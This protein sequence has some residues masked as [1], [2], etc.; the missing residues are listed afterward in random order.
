MTAALRA[1]L[2]LLVLAVSACKPQA[3]E[4]APT[5][6]FDAKASLVAYLTG[7][8]GVHAARGETWID[9]ADDARVQ[10]SVCAFGPMEGDPRRHFL[11]A[12]CGEWLARGHSSPGLVDFHLLEPTADGFH[13]TATARDH[14]F[15][16]D[17]HPGTVSLV[18]L[19]RE[20]GGFLV[21]EG[22]VGQGLVTGTRSIVEF[23]DG[24]LRTLAAVRSGIA[25]AGAADCLE[26]ADC[27]SSF[28]V[29]F[30]QS[31]DDSAPAADAYPLLV[32]ETG[33][34]CGAEVDRRHRFAFDAASG[35]YPV[36]ATL[37]RE[38]CLRP[39]NPDPE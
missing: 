35:R 15:G 23:R 14:G 27:A 25:N 5:P 18:R 6:A 2:A 20:R 1:V 38:D 9:G 21:E 19:G 8:Y 31:L 34:E 32:H 26:A 3:P 13:P 36:P 10:R 29:D 7:V 30:A 17:G 11:L 12:V 24:A 39:S 28:D 33:R 22:W 4:P 16:S 37:M